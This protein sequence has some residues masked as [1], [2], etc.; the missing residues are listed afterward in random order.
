[1]SNNSYYQNIALVS[2]DSNVQNGI[3]LP[4]YNALVSS[5]NGLEGSRKVL[6][7]SHLV[8]RKL[9]D[10]MFMDPY[11]GIAVFRLQCLGHSQLNL[12]M[13]DLPLP[14]QHV[15]VIKKSFA[16]GIVEYSSVVV[17]TTEKQDIFYFQITLASQSDN[18]LGSL[19]VSLSGEPLGVVV[20]RIANDRL[21]ILPLRYLRDLFV[22]Y[23]NYENTYAFRCPFCREILTED[24]VTF[25]KCAF[26]GEILPTTLYKPKL[27]HIGREII[28]IEKVISNLNYQ[29]EL[30]FLGRNF[31][32]IE[33]S[34][35]SI[36]FYYDNDNNSLVI[37]STL[38]NLA[39]CIKDGKLGANDKHHVYR[40][41]LTENEKMRHM[42]FSLNEQNILLSSVYLDMEY[43]SEQTLTEFVRDFIARLIDN[44]HKL[45][46]FFSTLA[47]RQSGTHSE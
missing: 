28:K 44:K 2:T 17:R 25:D 33:K 34:G 3:I 13:V 36:V 32:E 11:Y 45:D 26:C 24:L 38:A 35:L 8:G 40:Y 19:V 31:W 46:H 30:T 42:F 39:E 27:R 18:I 1:M 20:R 10:V 9:A 47:L 21:E 43:V 16:R 14:G 12:E 5:Y 29:P 15:K 4:E 7:R 23:S 6:V 22:E 37:Y 41:L